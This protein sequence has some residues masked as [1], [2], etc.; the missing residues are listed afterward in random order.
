MKHIAPKSKGFTLIE[1]LVVIAII[2]ILAA[3]LFPV[4]QKVRENA[5]KASC[6]SNLKQLGLAIV[7]Y[8]QDSDELQPPAWSSPD[9]TW[10]NKTLRWSDVIYPFVKS[11]GAF[12]CP[13]V[14]GSTFVTPPPTPVTNAFA[15]AQNGGYVVNAAYYAAGDGAHHRPFGIRD[16]GNKITINLSQIQTRRHD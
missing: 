2:A 14:S 6:Q 8:T 1:L 9:G 13:D 15:N 10:A 3:I 12:T 11:T 4:F 5:R 7:Q 16:Q